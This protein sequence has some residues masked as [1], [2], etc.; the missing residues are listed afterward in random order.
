MKL[1]RAAMLCFGSYC[2][3]AMHSWLHAVWLRRTLRRGL[4]SH[5]VVVLHQCAPQDIQ[6]LVRCPPAS[7]RKGAHID[8]LSGYC[9]LVCRCVADARLDLLAG[10]GIGYVLDPVT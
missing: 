7:T 8:R 6:S 3:R 5:E 4:Q 1:Q 9:G 10:C 2:Q